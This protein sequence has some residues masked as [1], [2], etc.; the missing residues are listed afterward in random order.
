MGGACSKTSIDGASGG[1]III[2]RGDDDDDDVTEGADARRE[3]EAE[4]TR[5][6]VKQVSFGD[7]TITT[8]IVM[9]AKM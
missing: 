1:T 7:E 5:R 4:A 3:D 8:T 6:A 9:R 2:T